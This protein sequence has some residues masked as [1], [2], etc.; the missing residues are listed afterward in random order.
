MNMQRYSTELLSRAW[1]AVGYPLNYLCYR[2]CRAGAFRTNGCRSL[3]APAH[4]PAPGDE[5]GNPLAGRDQGEIPPSSR[6][7]N[8]KG[9][10][11]DPADGGHRPRPADAGA[12]QGRARH[13]RHDPCASAPPPA[14]AARGRSEIVQTDQG[15]IRCEIVVNAAGYYAQRVGEWFKALWRAHRADDGHGAPVT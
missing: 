2:L 5:P 11:Y 6:P 9:A 8:L 1:R 10:L 12:G 3:P 4:G 13:G 15:D 7:M 14:S